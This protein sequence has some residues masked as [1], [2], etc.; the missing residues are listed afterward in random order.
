MRYA[1][2]DRLAPAEYRALRA[3]AGWSDPGVDDAALEAHARGDVE[4]HGPAG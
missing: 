4:R 2:G 3:A 1:E